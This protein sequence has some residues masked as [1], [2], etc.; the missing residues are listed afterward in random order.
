VT[1]E[2]NEYGEALPPRVRLHAYESVRAVLSD[3]HNYARGVEA[4][5]EVAGAVL[6]EAGV[7]GLTETVVEL[8][9]R[10]ADALE[11]IAVDQGV[12]AVDLAEV[13]FAD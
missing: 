4:A 9:L 6:A 5:R 10:L 7:D 1:A 2:S 12:A 11:R 3:D 8:S 13:W